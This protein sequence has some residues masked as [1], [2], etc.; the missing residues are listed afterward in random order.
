MMHSGDEDDEFCS[1]DRFDQ[2]EL[3][4]G[5]KFASTSIISLYFDPIRLESNMSSRV[6]LLIVTCCNFYMNYTYT[7]HHKFFLIIK[8][9]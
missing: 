6:S 8:I 3:L 2:T 4:F 7:P 9:I 5:S 1:V